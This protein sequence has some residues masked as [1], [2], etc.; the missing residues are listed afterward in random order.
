LSPQ[1]DEPD[2]LPSSGTQTA[3]NDLV[4]QN[5]VVY[6]SQSKT[7]TDEDETITVI[8]HSQSSQ[9]NVVAGIDDRV[10]DQTLTRK[11]S[12]LRRRKEVKANVAAVVLEVEANAEPQLLQANTE[13]LDDVENELEQKPARR[14][15]RI[16]GQKKKEMTHSK[17]SKV[18]CSSHD[19]C[20][21][22]MS[23][24]HEDGTN[25]ADK[26]SIVEKQL[27]PKQTRRNVSHQQQQN[28]NKSDR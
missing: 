25:T 21:K 24:Q 6:S 10:Q 2:A 22:L 8:K 20:L 28:F 19:I 26:T 14:S 1:H 15:L 5:S 23:S 17:K 7:N 3:S 27:E 18:D 11:S 9:P 16:C 13:T 4:W 12:R